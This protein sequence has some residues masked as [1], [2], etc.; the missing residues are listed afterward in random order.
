M[1]RRNAELRVSPSI[2]TATRRLYKRQKLLTPDGIPY[3]LRRSRRPVVAQSSP[4][5]F[6]T[7]FLGAI[8]IQAPSPRNAYK[9]FSTSHYHR[10]DY[11]RHC[12][13]PPSSSDSESSAS[14]QGHT[15]ASIV[16]ARRR[17]ARPSYTANTATVPLLLLRPLLH[18]LSRTPPPLAVVPRSLAHGAAIHTDLWRTPQQ[19]RTPNP[20][21]LLWSPQPPPAF[22]PHS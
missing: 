14:T 8:L 1:R 18:P 20:R 15:S 5:V 12:H 2:V 10:R 6:S 19:R 7:H 16:R 4:E 22:L 3:A 9:R 11:L 13:Q 17:A 21:S